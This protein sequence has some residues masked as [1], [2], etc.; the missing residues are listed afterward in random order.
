M[1]SYMVDT[2]APDSPDFTLHD[3]TG[4]PGDGIT[5]DA[6]VDVTLAGDAASWQYSLNS[7]STWNTGSGTSF[8]LADNT[9]YNIGDI[10]VHQTDLAGNVSSET[11][12]TTTITTDMT[13]AA[14]SFSLH[15]DNGTPGDGITNDATVDVILA[16]DAASWE[17]SLN[18]GSTWNT[19]SGTSFE[20]ADNTTYNIG[21]IQVHQTD[22]A[23][24]VSNETNNAS[25][26]TTD[27]ANPTFSSSSPLDN[28][29]DVPLTSDITITFNEN[30][31]LGT[32]NIIITDGSDIRT[33]DVENHSGQLSIAGDTLTIDPSLDLSNGGST[34]HVEVD[35]GAITDIAGNGYAGTVDATTFETIDTSIVVFDLVNGNSSDHSSRTFAADIDY[36]VYILVDSNSF[37]LATDSHGGAVG[38]SWGTW[39]GAN[40]LG[41]NDSIVIVGDSGPIDI[42][43]TS[44][45][46]A[47]AD[48]SEVVTN[49]IISLHQGTPAFREVLDLT[50]GG[51]LSR[52]LLSGVTHTTFKAADL[53]NGTAANLVGIGADHYL[54]AM[55]TNILTSQG[56]V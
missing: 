29:T 12:N 3:D 34:Y 36:T 17:Y 25:A 52:Y 53:W 20:L 49:N 13:I 21:D 15:A 38:A 54:Q 6:T 19:G 9:I 7:G 33:I 56:L 24:N 16:V 35:S 28:A 30:I 26:I 47:V 42:I 14:P 48:G 22:L 4:T 50:R 32:G 43:P 55:P 39:S 1:P 37:S 18:G 8:E 46:V 31:A 10:Q 40:N 44:T 2:T 51:Q 5:N 27:M 11:S 45:P 23:G 41:S